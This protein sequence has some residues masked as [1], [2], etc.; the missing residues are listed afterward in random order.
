MRVKITFT[1]GTGM[2]GHL[3][4]HWPNL[5]DVM[6]DEHKFINFRQ[7]N[8]RVVMLNKTS[9]AYIVEESDD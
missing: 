1:N 2:Y 9:I 4:T 7:P 8:D 3:D 5:G 6:N